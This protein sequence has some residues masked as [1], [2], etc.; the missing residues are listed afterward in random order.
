MRNIPTELI[1]SYFRD[2]TMLGLTVAVCLLALAYCLYVGLS[3]EVSDLQVATRY[4]AFGDTHFYRN[5]WYYLLS[6]ILFGI[7]VATAHVALAVKLYGRQQ[8]QFAIALL[9]FTLFFISVGWLITRSVLQIA[10]L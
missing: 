10:F 7:I 5:K 2:R 3:L 8:R 6:F 1:K 4:T 9:A